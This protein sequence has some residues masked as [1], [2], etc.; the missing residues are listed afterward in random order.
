MTTRKLLYF[1]LF[2]LVLL[3]A[4]HVGVRATVRVRAEGPPPGHAT[5]EAPPPAPGTAAEAPP[6]AP[7]TAAEAPPPPPQAP[8]RRNLGLGEVCTSSEQCAHGLTCTGEPGC[9]QPWTC[10]QAHPCTRDLVPFCGCDGQVFRSSSTCPGRPYRNRG[11]CAN[12][13]PAP[14]PTPG[15]AGTV[16]QGGA[17]TSSSDCA[18]GLMCVGHEGCDQGATC[19]PRHPCTMDLVPFCGCDGQTFRGSST[20][21]PRSFRHRGACQSDGPLPQIPRRDQ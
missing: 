20:C 13:A 18:E 1:P 11:A 15:A 8:A 16:G 21:P 6:P 10:Q 12:P 7:G 5:A 14:A 9:G 17:C 4:C 2:P 3:A 19:E